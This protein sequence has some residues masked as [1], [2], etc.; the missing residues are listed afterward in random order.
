METNKNKLSEQLVYIK[1]YLTKDLAN[2]Y[3]V[4]KKTMIRWLKKIQEN[5]GP[6]F[7]NYYTIPQVRI[8]FKMLDLPSYII[9]KDETSLLSGRDDL[10]RDKVSQNES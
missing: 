8:I 2:I 5:L 4:S 9:L 10:K 6:R 7:G 3:G 1:P